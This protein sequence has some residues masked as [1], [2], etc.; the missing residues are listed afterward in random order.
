MVR[1]KVRSNQGH[2]MTLHTHTHTP[3]NVPTRYQLPIPYSFLDIART[4]FHRSR[5]LRQDTPHD[6]AHLH[7]LTNV[8]S[9]Y[10]LP[11]P[12]RFRDIGQIRFYR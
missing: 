3:T 7:L 6:N 10:Q 11:T 2:I 1:S 12:Y 5:S 9:K 4:R 8:P